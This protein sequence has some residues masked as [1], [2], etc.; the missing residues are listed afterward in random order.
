MDYYEILEALR[1]GE[2]Q[3]FVLSHD[4]FPLFYEV[5]RNYPY[6]NTIRGIA[7]QGGQVTYVR[8]DEKE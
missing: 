8:A 4:D 6:Q 2:R 7:A 3:E 5:W 1:L